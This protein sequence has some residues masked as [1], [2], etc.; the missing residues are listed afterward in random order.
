MQM[1]VTKLIKRVRLMIL[2]LIP[3]EVNPDD[4]TAPTSSIITPAVI[5]AFADAGGDFGEAVPFALLQ[6]RAQFLSEAKASRESS[7]PLDRQRKLWL[8]LAVLQRLITMRTPAVRPLPKF[9]LG[10]S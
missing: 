4:L 9:S 6:A 1:T 8:I 2:K 5:Q 3:V 7:D 10:G